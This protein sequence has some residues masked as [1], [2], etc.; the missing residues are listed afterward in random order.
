MSSV[1]R[2][3]PRLQ[4]VVDEVG[5]R[6]R[7]LDLVQV[8]PVVDAPE[9]RATDQGD[10]RSR[11]EQRR[12]PGST[13]E[14]FEAPARARAFQDHGLTP[15]RSRKLT[16]T[17]GGLEAS[18]LLELDHERRLEGLERLVEA[19]DVDVRAVALEDSDDT[20]ERD[21]LRVLAV[22]GEVEILGV[23]SLGSQVPQPQQPHDHREGDEGDEALVG[24]EAQADRDGEEEEGQLLGLL[25][26]RAEPDD[27]ERGSLIAAR[28]RTIESAP[29]RPRE[30]ARDDFTIEMISIVVTASRTKLRANRRRFESESP[31]RS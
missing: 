26:R 5:E 14:R 3:K 23:G 12:E 11:A 24:S 15:F 20:V 2:P 30:S 9:G 25:D 19:L 27:R 6:V 1:R 4:D 7:D 10:E 16:L 29:T 8:H 13:Q 21:L 22:D 17:S 18:E 28:N 31:K